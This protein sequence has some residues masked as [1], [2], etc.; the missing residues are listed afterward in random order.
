MDRQKK[1][2]IILAVY[3]LAGSLI[4]LYLL[5]KKPGKAR[6]FKAEK[7]FMAAEDIPELD[8]KLALP[9]EKKKSLCDTLMLQLTGDEKI[10]EINRSYATANKMDYLALTSNRN[11]LKIINNVL[12][13]TKYEFVIY[14]SEPMIVVDFDKKF[15]RLFHQAGDSDLILA[16]DEDKKVSLNVIILRNSQWAKNKIGQIFSNGT[17]PKVILDPISITCSGRLDKFKKIEE[18]LPYVTYNICVFN[19]HAF[20]SGR[21]SFIVNS[22]RVG[23]RSDFVKQCYEAFQ[24]EKKI[25]P[26]ALKYKK[27][28]IYPWKGIPGFQE[29]ERGLDKLDSLKKGS[30]SNKIPKYI[31]QTMKT[32]LLP[33][34][35]VEKLIDPLRGG[36]PGHQY[37]FFDNLD[38]RNFIRDNFSSQT[39]DSYL[40]VIPGAFKSDLWRYCILYT[41][42]GCY[43]DIRVL[44]LCGLDEI[45]QDYSFVSPRDRGIIPA[46]FQAILFSCPQNP[47]LRN[48]INLACQNI[49]AERPGPSTLDIT[50]PRL[51]GR[52][53]LDF[54]GEDDIIFGVCSHGGLKYKILNFDGANIKDGDKVVII[55]RGHPRLN[56]LLQKEDLWYYLLGSCHYSKLWK[57]D[58]LWEN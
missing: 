29:V 58:Q 37:F 6:K 19:E 56:F 21:S 23:A 36:N 33:D 48:S 31:F 9:E 3:L 27:I 34:H 32:N 30:D 35:V 5:L 57:L 50:G 51:V 18:G 42:G 52:V 20:N 22:S 12:Y 28:E 15:D 10:K 39:Y 25:T 24:K 46:F 38:C 53:F 43:L 2:L 8:Q 49:S 47:V 7:Y 44:P 17:S 40:K 1:I 41:Y 14:L 16:R 54:I 4:L 45:T 26:A 55:A 11:P 13:L